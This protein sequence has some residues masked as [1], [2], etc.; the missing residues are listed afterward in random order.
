[1]PK[2]FHSNDVELWVLF[3][4]KRDACPW[5]WDCEQWMIQLSVMR[6]V[7]CASY[8]FKKPGESSRALTFCEFHINRTFLLQLRGW[9][10]SWTSL[11]KRVKKGNLID[12]LPPTSYFWLVKVDPALPCSSSGPDW[13]L[14]KL[15]SMFPSVVFHLNQIWKDVLWW[16]LTL[17]EKV[18]GNLSTCEKAYHV[19]V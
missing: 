5:G 6:Y 16:V 3:H 15:D 10:R 7:S 18:E 8:W 14:R 17:I 2:Y 1:M 9:A 19:Y 11:R 13:P 12:Q 4:F